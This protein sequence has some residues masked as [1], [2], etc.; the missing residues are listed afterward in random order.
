MKFQILLFPPKTLTFK[1]KTLGC[2][3]SLPACSLPST[4]W[5]AYRRISSTLLAFYPFPIRI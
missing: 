4:K 5:R 1:K 3:N 2:H